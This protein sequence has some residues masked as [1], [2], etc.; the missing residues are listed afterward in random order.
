MTTQR[1]ILTDVDGVILDWE[2]AFHEWMTDLGHQAVDNYQDLHGM[3]RR[4]DLERNTSMNLVRQFNES[5]QIG[6][7][8]P[9]RDA[10]EVIRDLYW[11]DGYDF[12]MITAL[13]TNRYAQLARE[14]NLR[15]VL[16]IEFEIHYVDTA[17]PK[18][19]I[20]GEIAPRYPGCVWVE[21]NPRNADEGHSLG[22]EGVV[23]R[24][25]H[26]ANYSGPCKM[27]D[28]WQEIATI[29]EQ[30]SEVEHA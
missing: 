30:L 1:T 18:T 22:L 10:V 3:H 28:T 26:N 23:I 5:A 8:K 9:F 15:D 25:T 19:D 14:R 16:D 4:Y 20:L 6:F 24:H 13:G 21:D 7:L 17:A 12:V 27:V 2:N 11:G 29:V